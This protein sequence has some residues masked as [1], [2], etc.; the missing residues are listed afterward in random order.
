[1]AENRPAYQLH[2][3]RED[4]PDLEKTLGKVSHSLNLPYTELK[5]KILE[6]KDLAQFKPIILNEDLNYE[7]AM[8]LETYQDNFPGVSIVIHPRR[9]YPYKNLFLHPTGYFL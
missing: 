3:I 7:K 1:M 6:K 9:Y 2:L 4:T 5:Q 8:Y